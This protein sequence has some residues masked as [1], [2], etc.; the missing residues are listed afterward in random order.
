MKILTRFFLVVALITSVAILF[1]NK[2]NNSSKVATGNFG[3]AEDNPKARAEWELKRLRSPFTGKI[4]PGIRAKE[5]AYAQTLPS[6][7]NFR[8]GKNSS[9]YTWTPR[10]P[11]NVGGRTRALAIDFTDEK[12][13]LAGGVSGGIWRTTDGGANWTMVTT[14]QQSLGITCIAQDKRTGK[15]NIWYAGTGEG[16][17][18]SAGSNGAYYNGDG[19]LKSTD[20]GLTW[21][22]LPSTSTNI[23]QTWDTYYEFAWRILVDPIDTGGRVF[24]AEIGTIARTTNGGSSWTIVKNSFNSS[25]PF[26]FSYY[27]DIAVAANGVYYAVLSSEGLSSAVGIW[28]SPNGIT[29]T[30]ITPANFPSAYRRIVI[31]I[32]PVDTNQVYFLGQTPGSG[33]ITFNYQKDTL[34]HSLWKYTYLSGNGSGTGGSW[35]DR[36]QNLP[37]SGSGR[38]DGWDSQGGYDLAIACHPTDTNIVFIGGTNIFRSTN[39][40]KD[41]VNTEKI[42]GYKIGTDLPNVESYPNQ[43]SD[44]HGLTFL[45]SNPNVL[46]SFCDG[47]IFKTMDCL[48]PS[49]SWEVLNNGYLTTQFYTVGL[50]RATPGSNI[51]LGGLQDNGTHFLNS[52]YLQEPWNHSWGGDGSY[53]SVADGAAFYYLS[54]QLGKTYKV[55]LDNNGNKVSWARID[56]IGGRGY[57]FINPFVMDPNNN[58]IMYLT[59]GSHLWRNND[60]SAVPLNNTWDSISTNWVDFPDTLVGHSISAIAVSK[61]PANIIY[62]GTDSSKVYRVDNANIGTPVPINI[63]GNNFPKNADVTPPITTYDNPSVSCIAIDPRDANKVIVVFSNYETYSVFYTEDGGTSWKKVAGNLEQNANG[64]G[65]GPSCRWAA[66]LDEGNGKTTYFLAT[67]IG[68][69]ST[70]TLIDNGTVWVQEGASS[71]G[72]AVVDMIDVRSSDKAVVV[73]THGYGMF[74]ANM[75]TQAGASGINSV[76]A[77]SLLQLK[78]YPNPFS[79]Q[80]NIEITLPYRVKL[81][82]KIYDINGKEIAVLKN[83]EMNAGTHTIP[84]DSKNLPAGIYFCSLKTEKFQQS[85]SLVHF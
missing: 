37:S 82:L 58:N 46:I 69:Y 31:G 51:I 84:F 25:S 64:S 85:I 1:F 83:E 65:N 3:E 2:K 50:D 63:T 79:E 24:A 80:T 71:I 10:G 34:W 81:A 41:I 16:T 61:N 33:K 28:R 27:T 52:T 47:G 73:G 19:I 74:T 29:W 32:S 9:A 20:G 12:I 43:H 42:G 53:L 76:N 78:N 60:L 21:A 4:P 23:P 39:Q 14:P 48:A 66:F 72:N 57:D 15:T 67:S 8:S 5:L 17:G 55:V 59:A 45:P 62:F 68:L 35:E 18:T 56:P 77:N 22:L 70:D 26:N 75:I 7:E 36:S 13:M 54:I 40:F 49:V 30:K 38:F 6:K 44:Q 11:W